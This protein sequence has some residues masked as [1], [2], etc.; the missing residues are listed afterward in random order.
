MESA[1]NRTRH[2][3]SFKSFLSPAVRKALVEYWGSDE[4]IDQPEIIAELGAEGIS[5]INR[6]GRKSLDEIVLA[7][8]R[9][10]YI[11]SLSPR[12]AKKRQQR[13][14]LK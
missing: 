8:H 9:L 7:L 12:P 11:D 5:R 6:I 13:Y 2:E 3:F 4:I 14:R 1:N 10:G